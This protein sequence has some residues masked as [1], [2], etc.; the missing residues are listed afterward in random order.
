MAA[1]EQDAWALRYVKDQTPQL[2]LAAIRKSC[3]VLQFVRD[4][5][6][7]IC[8]TALS[9]NEGTFAHVKVPLE[10]SLRQFLLR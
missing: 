8:I 7:E 5:T 2:C 10:V 9:L 6:P 3:G 1:I 4:K